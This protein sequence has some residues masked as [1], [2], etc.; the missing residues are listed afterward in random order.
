MSAF[1]SKGKL[2][3]F[4]DNVVGAE[5]QDEYDA[6]QYYYNRDG[7]NPMDSAA[8]P[9]HGGQPYQAYG[10]GAV[11][12]VHGQQVPM[13]PGQRH[14]IPQMGMLGRPPGAGVGG[15]DGFSPM[16]QT[17][18]G[19]PPGAYSGVPQLR[20]TVGMP[21]GAPLGA[22]GD[23]GIVP[24]Q[25]PPQMLPMGGGSS[26]GRG[27][28]FPGAGMDGS[29]FGMNPGAASSR[30]MSGM[31]MM[32]GVMP[33]GMMP[34]GAMT[35]GGVGMPPVNPPPN[36]NIHSEDFPALPSSSSSKGASTGSSMAPPDAEPSKYRE[37][38]AAAVRPS[39][40][41]PAAGPPAAQPA[42]PSGG[43]T[44][45]SR[46]YGGSSEAAEVAPS[47]ETRYGLLGLLDVIKMTDRDLNTLALGSDLTTF[48]LSLSSNDSLYLTFS[49]PFSDVPAPSEV[50]LFVTPQ[51][52]IMQPPS[53]KAEHMTKMHIET[54]FY[55]FYSM[56]RDQLQTA[57]ALELYRR[58]W[59]YH[60]DL[61]L[62]MKLRTPQSTDSA[63][64]AAAAVSQQQFVY[65]DVT[66]WEARI[67]SGTTLRVNGFLT[68]DEINMAPK[69]PG[70]G[71]VPNV[72]IPGNPSSGAGG[73]SVPPGGLSGGVSS[74]NSVPLSS[75]G[76]SPS[77]IVGPPGSNGVVAGSTSAAST[78]R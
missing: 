61:K 34:H 67:Y 44:G 76:A 12:G 39:A 22:H 66:T 23:L 48:G 29:G 64:S 73:V 58:D 71:S 8:P 33:F 41:R 17:R 65:F 7:V 69:Q 37:P 62:W 6:Q 72:I 15:Q 4:K 42:A 27:D 3:Y 35:D 78:T 11:Y 59:W 74:S 20:G 49:S 75:F 28:M 63:G 47:K 26:A 36:F 52:Y 18:P 46:P 24:G 70:G 1:N 51:C 10:A 25:L 9:L 57:A 53:L 54:L 56:P 30:Y 14:M 77:A 31:G 43:V 55:M 45:S 16:S 38:S 60:T 13:V 5:D 2:A 19:V 68:E 50:P 21:G 32:G 40:G